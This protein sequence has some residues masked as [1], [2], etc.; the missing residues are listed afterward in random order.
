[1]LVEQESMKENVEKIKLNQELR[2]I[3]DVNSIKQ[4][5]NVKI[6]LYKK[7]EEM[8]HRHYSILIIEIKGI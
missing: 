1:M 7:N 4:K 5:K 3:Q 8:S 6:K 2:L